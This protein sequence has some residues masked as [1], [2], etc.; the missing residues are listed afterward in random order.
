MNTCDQP[1]CGR[2]S[3]PYPPRPARPREAWATEN[4]ALAMAYV[5]MQHFKNV[6]EPD[7]ALQ[8][9]TLFPELNK[10]FMGWKGGRPC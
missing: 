9:G 4:F 2:N 10:P 5:P 7:E 1:R 8:I 3:Y 6:Y